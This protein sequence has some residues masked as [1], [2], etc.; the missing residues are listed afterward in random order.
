MR[1]RGDGSI[2]LTRDEAE[3]LVVIYELVGKPAIAAWLRN[4][5]AD[6]DPDAD[7]VMGFRPDQEVSN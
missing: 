5:L 1:R 3:R 2:E 7:V 6:L 4:R